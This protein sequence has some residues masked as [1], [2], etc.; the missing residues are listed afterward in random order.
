M[1]FFFIY[2]SIPRMVG[3][4]IVTLPFRC[5][6]E[7]V[8]MP[9]ELF[10]IVYIC[11]PIAEIKCHSRIENFKL[12]ESSPK[13]KFQFFQYATTYLSASHIAETPP[14]RCKKGKAESCE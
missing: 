5:F 12:T 2:K 8:E 13:L 11:S 14:S 1:P 4:A 7:E 9:F 6:Y 10:L 3:L